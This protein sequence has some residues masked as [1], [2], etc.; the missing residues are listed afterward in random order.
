MSSPCL[1]QNTTLSRDQYGVA[2]LPGFV[3]LNNLKCTDFVNV[4]R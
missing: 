3:G 4:S 2:Y 1:H